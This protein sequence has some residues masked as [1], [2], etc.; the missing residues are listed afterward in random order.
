MRG[1]PYQNRF[2]ASAAINRSTRKHSDC[3]RFIEQILPGF[4]NFDIVL[5][6]NDDRNWIL[7]KIGRSIWKWFQKCYCF[8][9]SW[10]ASTS[11]VLNGNSDFEDISDVLQLFYIRKC[12][13]R[14]TIHKQNLNFSFP[15][16]STSPI[17]TQVTRRNWTTLFRASN[18]EP[19]WFS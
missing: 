5:K 6:V 2:T 10:H 12:C 8:P 17:N 11:K 1:R 19:S 18:F 4:C 9:P 14:S 15:S 3:C 16:F 7:V 13:R